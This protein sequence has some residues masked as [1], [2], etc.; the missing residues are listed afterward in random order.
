MHPATERLNGKTPLCASIFNHHGIT[1]WV[2]PKPLV[3]MLP[4]AKHSKHCS[5]NAN[6]ANSRI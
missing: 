5:S 4:F 3:S 1:L 6:P 2:N